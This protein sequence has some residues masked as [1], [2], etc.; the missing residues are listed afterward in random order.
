MP[1]TFQHVTS[2]ESEF[3]ASSQASIDVSAH[4]LASGPN[5]PNRSTHASMHHRQNDFY[6]GHQ[7]AH[8]VS[9]VEMK[10]TRRFVS[11]AHI[12]ILIN[13]LFPSHK[14]PRTKESQSKSS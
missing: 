3:S 12:R 4:T 8:K 7:S 1:Q 13:I 5:T 2:F 10:S 11:I 14:E 9:C 6:S